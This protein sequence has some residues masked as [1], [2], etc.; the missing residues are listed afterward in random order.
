MVTCL[1]DLFNAPKGPDG[2]FPRFSEYYEEMC[3]SCKDRYN[4]IQER[5]NA[6]RRLGTAK[7]GVETVGKRLIAVKA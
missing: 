7:R 1:D 5:K 6:R 4:A 2:E 3:E